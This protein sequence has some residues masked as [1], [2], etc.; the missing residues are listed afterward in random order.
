MK[1]ASHRQSNLCPSL[2]VKYITCSISSE[3][4]HSVENEIMNSVHGNSD[5]N[6]GT[7]GIHSHER[8]VM[9]KDHSPEVCIEHHSTEMPDYNSE[10]VNQSACV[11]SGK[12]ASIGKMF[13]QSLS[14]DSGL[15]NA[16]TTSLCMTG[17]HTC[18]DLTVDAIR[19][20]FQLA[21][22]KLLIMVPCCYHKMSMVKDITMTGEKFCNFP[23]S[24]SLCHLVHSSA[25][26]DSL[27]FLRHPFL[28]LAS[29]ETATRW[30]QWSEEDHKQHSLQVMARA[31]LQL[32]A[33]N[34]MQPWHELPVIMVYKQFATKT[35]CWPLSILLYCCQFSLSPFYYIVLL[36]P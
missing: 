15:F 16:R 9:N 35:H 23:L 11:C 14:S 18:G 7:A 33:H 27:C 8:H 5:C 34:G 29:Q 13:S 24:S 25:F 3:S 30:Q 36:T 10:E 28:R 6:C 21:S 1:T 26:C 22:V 4:L 17:L 32:C 2:A 19:L 31:V 20:F 12:F